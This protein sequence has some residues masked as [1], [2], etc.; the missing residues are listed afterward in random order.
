MF[1]HNK[2][3]LPLQMMYIL[4]NA[5]T[6]YCGEK[7]SK[8]VLTVQTSW[9][10]GT[11]WRHTRHVPYGELFT[12]DINNRLSTHTYTQWRLSSLCS[13]GRFQEHLSHWRNNGV[14]YRTK[15]ATRF[16]IAAVSAQYVPA[17]CQS[18]LKL[19]LYPPLLRKK[20]KDPLSCPWET[21]I[22]RL[23]AKACTC[24]TVC[25]RDW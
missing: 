21:S 5:H 14:I 15:G 8:T 13:E 24:E 19:L 23:F 6:Y 20:L 3:L 16:S 12:T 10:A 25:E 18:C 4:L 22:V 11:C 1:P 2:H 7:R 17:K 9:L